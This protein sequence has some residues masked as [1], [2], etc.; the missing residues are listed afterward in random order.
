MIAASIFGINSE[1]DK[2]RLYNAN[3]CKDFIRNLFAKFKEL[4]RKN[5]WVMDINNGSKI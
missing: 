2:I 3:I 5:D 4:A 1:A